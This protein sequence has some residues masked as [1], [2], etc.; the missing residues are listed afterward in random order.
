MV[1]GSGGCQ[2]FD[3]QCKKVR[4]HWCLKSQPPLGRVSDDS[5]VRTLR[6]LTDMKET[7]QLLDYLQTHQ[8]VG[9][10]MK[11]VHVRERV[12]GWGAFRKATIT[13]AEGQPPQLVSH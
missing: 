12:Q 3:R 10:Q 9:M 8:Q 4:Y 7:S 1:G 2:H 13:N 6:R 11:I 5:A